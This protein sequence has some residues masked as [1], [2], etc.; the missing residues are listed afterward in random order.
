MPTLSSNLEILEHLSHATLAFFLWVLP[1]LFS[2]NCNLSTEGDAN[3]PLLCHHKVPKYV[4][5]AQAYLEVL[6]IWAGAEKSG[7]QTGS[8]HTLGSDMYWGNW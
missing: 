7:P 2:L 6:T 5:W 3:L 8:P 1:K 4:T